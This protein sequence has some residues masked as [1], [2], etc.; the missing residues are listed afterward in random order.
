MSVEAITAKKKV[1]LREQKSVLG[2][3][4]FSTIVVPH[5][6]A[7]LTKGITKPF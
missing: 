4:Q 5:G 6:T 2:K 7:F 1:T 3:L